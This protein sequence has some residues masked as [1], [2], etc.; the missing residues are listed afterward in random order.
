MDPA[1]AALW[2]RQMALGPAPEYCLLA[3]EAPAGV[4]TTRLAPGWS[5]TADAR[6]PL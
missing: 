1:R 6:A 2:Q 3:L 4:A 5:A